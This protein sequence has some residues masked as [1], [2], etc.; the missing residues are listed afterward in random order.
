MMKYFLLLFTLISTQAATPLPALGQDSN[1][2]I[3]TPY[4]DAK[5]TNHT[6][7]ATNKLDGKV[8]A[9]GATEG[10]NL[11]DDLADV[12]NPLRFGANKAG[13]L[14]SFTALT[15][16]LHFAGTNKTHIYLPGGTFLLDQTLYLTNGISIFG[17]PG[18]TILKAADS[19]NAPLIHIRSVLDPSIGDT[20]YPTILQGIV[21]D[22]TAITNTGIHALQIGTNGN[23]ASTTHNIKLH[24]VDIVGFDTT[25]SS[26]INVL[27]TVG[28]TIVGGLI[29]DNYIGLWINPTN[30]NYPTTVTLID[31][32]IRSSKLD[33]ILVSNIHGM[34]LLGSYV[35]ENNARYGGNFTAGVGNTIENVELMGGHFEGNQ[36]A[37]GASKT[38][39]FSLNVDGSAF[40]SGV[41][42][43][44]VDTYFSG[45]ITS[46]NAIRFINNTDFKIDSIRVYPKT[47]SVDINSASRGYIKNWDVNNSGD[48]LVTITNKSTSVFPDRGFG[49]FTDQAGNSALADTPYRPF[50]FW[51]TSNYI[52]L[53]VHNN[54]ATHGD[55]LQGEFF[56]GNV[57]INNH[58]GLPLRIG[59]GGTSSTTVYQS[60]DNLTT[61]ESAIASAGITSIGQVTSENI[62]ITGTTTITNFGSATLSTNYPYRWCRI[63][64]G[65]VTLTH[66]STYMQLPGGANII[67]ENN[68]RFLAK[69]LSETNW[70]IYT[71]IKANGYPVSTAFAQPIS[72]EL[73]L[74]DTN[75]PGANKYYGTDG[76]GLKGFHSLTNNYQY[77]CIALTNMTDDLAVG[78][79]HGYYIAPVNGTIRRVWG[80]LFDP[81]SSGNVTLDINLA[82]TTIM[83][84]TKITIEATEFW[85]GDATTQP[86]IT[87]SNFNAG[88]IITADIDA[89]GTDAKGGQVVLEWYPR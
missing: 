46:E 64:G 41:S 31:T 74:I 59:A 35:L 2:I 55:S 42:V 20:S 16:A 1:G 15:N 22:G 72:D 76:A 66:N 45:G 26:G 21:L 47:A 68:D 53:T 4:N 32:K 75:A 10:R 24:E 63:S 5:W 86:V 8:T 12:S 13:T 87:S 14:S 51:S 44:V 60:I 78:T 29:S 25:N 88:Q 33:G 27:N 70:I 83:A 48:E 69:N 73:T 7:V 9:S 80:N 3:R 71:Y 36:T 43:S 23:N 89:A 61:A 81:S 58:G 28:L 62:V 84:S 18:K 65:P 77:I 34:K 52:T 57:D 38:N 30:V 37:A 85:S 17:S 56:P 79:S 67:A 82:G 11:S 40:A 54:H 50:K 49:I 6:L 19:L 39:E